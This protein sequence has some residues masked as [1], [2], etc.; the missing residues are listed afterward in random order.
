MLLS[1]FQAVWVDDSGY[2]VAESAVML[3]DGSRDNT[4]KLIGTANI[5][6]SK[7]VSRQ[8]RYEYI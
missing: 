1:W 4:I 7:T 6:F 2:D 5:V 3:G 8:G